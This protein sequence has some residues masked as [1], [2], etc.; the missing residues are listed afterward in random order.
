[1]SVLKQLAIHNVSENFGLPREM[2]HEILGFCFYDRYTAVCR[3]GH[4]ENMA[5]IVVLFEKAYTSRA[6]LLDSSETWIVYMSTTHSENV[7]HASN[8]CTCGNY[9]WCGTFPPLEE[10]DDM[11]L[12]LEAIPI[13]MRCGCI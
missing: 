5:E 10:Q 2:A 8:C 3:A 7:F 4:K 13:R 1:M 11:Q 9:R 6:K 12:W